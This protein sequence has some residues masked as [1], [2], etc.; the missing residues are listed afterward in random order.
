MKITGRISCF[1]TIIIISIHGPLVSQTKK[2]IP[3][4][5]LDYINRAA[6]GDHLALEGGHLALDGHVMPYPFF[7]KHEILFIYKLSRL[8]NTVIWKADSLYYQPGWD[9]NNPK[10]TGEDIPGKKVPISYLAGDRLSHGT[11]WFDIPKLPENNSGKERFFSLQPIEMSLPG[12]PETTI[13]V[14]GNAKAALMRQHF[15]WSTNTLFDE[16]KSNR[17]CLKSFGIYDHPRGYKEVSIVERNPDID[18]LYWYMR[19]LVEA[20]SIMNEEDKGFVEMTTLKDDIMA[21]LDLDVARTTLFDEKLHEFLPEIRSRYKEI[22]SLS[23]FDNTLLMLNHG[24]LDSAWRW[25]LGNTDEKIERLVLNNLYLMDRY[26]EYRYIFTTPY[27][28]ERLDK[29]YPE[30]FKR[31]KQKISNGQW[32]ANG[33]TYVENDMN[34]PGGESIVRQ[35]LYGLSYYED[36]L[37]VH[38]NTLFLPD[39]FG[40]PRF[41]P[42]IAQSFGLDHLIGMRVNTDEIDHTI[43]RWKGIDGSEILVNGL[44][45][46]AWEYPFVDAIHGYRIKNPNH[47]TTY[48]APDPGPRR[49]KG[50]WE[51][52]KD[53][54]VTNEQ[55]MLI[56]WGDGG[57]GGTEDQIELKRKVES[58]PSFP[59]VK[60]T[61]LYDYIEG[62][63]SNFDKF[64][65]FDKGIIPS[66]WIRRTFLMANGIKI[67]NRKAEQSLRELEALS[68][69]ASRYGMTYPESEIED[70]WKQLLLQHFHDIITG[71]AVPEVLKQ[72]NETLITI[73]KRAL[74]LRDRSLDY[75]IENTEMEADGLLVF[76]P[77]GTAYSGK[78]QISGLSNMKGVDL[79]DESG[80]ALESLRDQGD[81]LVY[82]KNIPPMSFAKFYWADTRKKPA[83]EKMKATNQV[84]ENKLVKVRFN[85]SGE[86]IS[87]YDKE[88]DRELVPSGKT[89]NR[90][91]T[92]PLNNGG[93]VVERGNI[94]KDWNA[95]QMKQTEIKPIE[96]N[97]LKVS[98]EIKRFFNDSE[99][100][101]RVSLT[102]GSKQLEFDTELDWKE[103]SRLEVNFPMSFSTNY[104][105]HG[106]QWGA[107]T[108]ER[109]KFKVTDS[110]HQPLC[111]H[112]WADVSD[113][114]YGIAL[115]DNTR[116][117]YNLKT[118]GI[119]L[120]LSYMRKKH[121]YT[122]LKDVPWDEDAS[123]D[124]GGNNFSYA[125]VP[126]NGDVYAANIIQK[127]KI[128]NTDLI[129]R[130]LDKKEKLTTLKNREI[131]GL[132]SNL[133]D[134][135][136]FQTIKKQEDG[137]GTIIRLYETEQ[138]R[139]K[140]S[141]D[142]SFQ[143]KSLFL[144]TMKEEKLEQ[145]EVINEKFELTFKPFEIKTIL[146]QE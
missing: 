66:Q 14:N 52:F 17:I 7:E 97:F 91:M 144:T 47:Y 73:N 114:D 122:E 133:P 26:P 43:Y 98:L 128:F 96:N 105:S 78:V 106:I 38:K 86:I 117:G 56:G 102:K 89:W 72:A 142:L 36:E 27:H 109:S 60:W 90:L 99:I 70:L 127:A 1:L 80:N 130:E 107:N 15:Y 140:V 141:I 134:N 23:D 62:Q 115:F 94:K 92:V 48:N 69:M 100:L 126:H 145:I 42:Q 104:A 19:V 35:F 136:I 65:L 108:V 113:K 58:L 125:I 30:L 2:V 68:L 81:L 119:R 29:L 139:C 143:E 137:N 131:K 85:E 32:I 74:T 121:N 57:G 101:Q 39:T 25:T 71:M 129:I 51:R 116:Y 146:I 37:N 10:I 54:D 111:V 75:I 41:L 83:S 103:P 44:S 3:G 40:Y 87:F 118:G 135:I 84:L 63:K 20:T 34:L 6:D 110:L 12:W 53:K 61:S 67:N 120:V 31:V 132:L 49:L 13:Y 95:S 55:L 88:V 112:Q 45:T 59:K 21:T 46:P 16:S 64:P 11:Y 33:S 9:D 93:M 124:K 5:T 8:R 28:Y 24:H 79:I 123:G 82:V 138:K 22:E 50:T 4:S 18:A 77:A 76:N